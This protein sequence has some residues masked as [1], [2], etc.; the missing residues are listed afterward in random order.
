MN[1]V[2][3][4]SQPPQL[5]LIFEP[6][7][8]QT[9]PQVSFVAHG[10]G[11]TLFLTPNQAVM[12][13][14]SASSSTKPDDEIV[15]THQTAKAATVLRF[16]M[17]GANPSVKMVG[18]EQLTSHSNYF[19]GNDASKWHS[20]VANYARVLYQSIYPG[21]DLDYYSNAGK[22]EHDFMVAP[23]AN[24]NMI[25]MSIAG[26]DKV[27]VVAGEL[28]V[29]TAS[30]DLREKVPQIYQ[31]GSNGRQEISGNYVLL[32][33]NEIGFNVTAY[34]A[35]RTLVIDPTTEFS[36]RLG[37]SA[38]DEGNGI[39]VDDQGNVYVTGYTLSTT[40]FP[41]TPGAYQ[42]HNA[43]N[44]DVF[45]TKIAA[46]GNS[47]VFSTYIGGQYTD[48][49]YAIAVD[50]SYNVYITGESG[51]D[52]PLVN[53]YP[54]N[55]PYTGGSASVFVTRLNPLGNSIAY[56]SHLQHPV[57]EV[58]GSAGLAIAVDSSGDAYVTGNT[59]AGLSTTSNAFCSIY[60]SFAI[61]NSNAYVAEFNTNGAGSSSLLYSS[62]VGRGGDTVQ[63]GSI[64]KSIALDRYGRIYITGLSATFDNNFCPYPAAAMAH[65]L[66]PNPGGGI[67]AFVIQMNLLG[68]G[69][70]SI[71]Y[72]T[73][74][75]GNAYDEGDGIAVDNNLNVYVTGFTGSTNFYT[76]NGYQMNPVGG[77]DAYVTK[78]QV[79]DT[80]PRYSTYLGSSL[81][82]FG[83]K[84]AVDD[85]GYAFVTGSTSYLDFPAVNPLYTYGGGQDAFV[86][87]L[88]TTSAGSFSLPFSTYLGGSN[89]DYG[90]SIAIDNNDNI[91]VAG[92]TESSNF[93]IYNPIPGITGGAGDGFVTKISNTDACNTTLW[94]V[95]PSFGSGSD[96]L[97][98]IA[99]VNNAD[100]VAAGETNANVQQQSGQPLYRSLRRQSMARDDPSYTYGW[101]IQHTLGWCSC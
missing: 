55:P 82:D 46:P 68:F 81:D 99:V 36:T 62:Y 28:V 96:V 9:D 77:Y 43:G 80:S 97:N 95:S 57:N 65:A 34:D 58:Y 52:Y 74:L 1:Q 72:V 70:D 91:F 4:K 90:N 54:V 18:Q 3:P 73:Y 101:R 60:R 93:P 10:N 30:G 87:E 41:I 38:N 42:I 79:G 6:N 53:Q 50:R 59:A 89:R 39:A 56:S 17:Q 21:I 2:E 33:E 47:L 86:A 11:Y 26:A 64:G 22:L 100:V 94:C 69:V 13:L 92:Y 83:S 14:A 61:N 78:F 49:A 48:I 66:Q 19:I 24:P 16:Q 76:V 20:Y 67:D 85:N 98:G 8:G 23:G 31:D 40:D 32:G 51:G 75:G 84:I 7:V 27:E 37:G 44:E 45:V 71:E 15:K 63:N 88:K 25:R 29:H 5:P 35:T 12:T